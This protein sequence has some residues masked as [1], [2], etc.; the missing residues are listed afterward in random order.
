ML[1]VI[2]QLAFDHRGTRLHGR[3]VATFDDR[4]RCASRVL[5]FASSRILID[6]GVAA[7]RRAGADVDVMTSTV[8][9]GTK[10]AVG[11]GNSASP[12]FHLWGP[13]SLPDIGPSI[14]FDER[15]PPPDTGQSVERIRD[16]RAP[17]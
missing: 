10:W 11:E 5:P 2:L 17:C 1:R 13:F 9:A 14:R 6:E 8:S 12:T 16:G 4:Q 7:T 15:S 3:F